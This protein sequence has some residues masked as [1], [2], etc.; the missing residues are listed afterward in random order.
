MQYM[1][2]IRLDPHIM[3]QMSEEQKIEWVESCPTKV[4]QYNNVTRVVRAT[5]QP[6]RRIHLSPA[7]AD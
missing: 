5:A 2:E 4:F 1:P 3:S 6:Y 7:V